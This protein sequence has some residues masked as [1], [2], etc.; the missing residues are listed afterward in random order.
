MVLF[1]VSQQ[2]ASGNIGNAGSRLC[3]DQFADAA[4]LNI[5]LT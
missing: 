5:M 4:T 1:L 2:D 3:C